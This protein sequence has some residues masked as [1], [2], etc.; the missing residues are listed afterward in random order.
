MI[1]RAAGPDDAPAVTTLWNAMIRDTAA[2]F[3]TQE[4]TVA[5]MATRITERRGAFWVA[6]DDAAALAGFVTFGPFRGGPG[7]GA[8]IEHTVILDAAAQGRGLGHLLMD[9]AEAGARDMGHHIMVAAISSANPKARNFH[10]RQGFSETGYMPQVG[11]KA[12]QWLD[13]ILMQKTISAS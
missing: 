6:L 10:A 7:Y 12:G 13:L 11:R 5:A 1:L 2:T 4:W 9:T 3:T 8:T